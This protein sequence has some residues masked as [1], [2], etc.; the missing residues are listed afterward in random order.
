MSAPCPVCRG[1]GF[2]V[3]QDGTRPACGACAGSGRLPVPPPG[4]ANAAGH[5][6]PAPLQAPAA[7]PSQET[8][9]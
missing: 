3:T 2:R 5:L 7:F 4:R 6:P 8:M 9:A 1:R